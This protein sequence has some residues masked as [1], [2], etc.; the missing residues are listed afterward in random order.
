MNV[1]KGNRKNRSVTSVKGLALRVG[2]RGLCTNVATARGDYSESCGP[3][4][5]SFGRLED[6]SF[7]DIS[8]AQ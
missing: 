7:G 2:P 6:E 8:L 4:G 1:N 3:S 5:W